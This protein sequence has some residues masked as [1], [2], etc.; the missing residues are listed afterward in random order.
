MCK[1][2]WFSTCPLN[3]TTDP[4]RSYTSV[5]WFGRETKV[6]Y[7]NTHKTRQ[8]TKDLPPLPFSE[9]N[10]STVDSKNRTNRLRYNPVK[11]RVPTNPQKSERNIKRLVLNRA[12][13]QKPQRRE[14]P[15]NA[16]S[17]HSQ[18]RADLIVWRHANKDC[19]PVLVT[20]KRLRRLE[21]DLRFTRLPY[22]SGRPVTSQTKTGY[23]R[24]AYFSRCTKRLTMSS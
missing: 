24:S 18:E 20:T 16:Q 19:T 15:L 21:F 8:Q 2:L 13:T 22:S 17:T 7:V 10:A 23:F 5:V 11:R 3:G 12:K 9:K 14:N 1:W 6:S 4:L